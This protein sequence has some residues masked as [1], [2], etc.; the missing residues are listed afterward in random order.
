MSSIFML[1]LS[2]ILIIGILVGFCVVVGENV[3]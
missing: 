1:L 2:F 3:V